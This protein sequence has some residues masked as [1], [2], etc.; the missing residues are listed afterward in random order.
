MLE[1]QPLAVTSAA[2]VSGLLVAAQ[3]ASPTAATYLALRKE[4]ESSTAAKGAMPLAVA[5]GRPPGASEK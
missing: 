1:V 3:G 5:R 2:E 4:T